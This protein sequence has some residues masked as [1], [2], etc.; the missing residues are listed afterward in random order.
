MRIKSDDI[1]VMLKRQKKRLINYIKYHD[2][3]KIIPDTFGN[4][5]NF[6]AYHKSRVTGPEPCV[7]YAPTRSIYID[8]YGKATPCCFNRIYVYGQYP[9]NSLLE[10]I[11]GDKR[12]FLQHQLC[13]SNFM[14]GCQ[15]C[16][17]LIESGNFEGTEARLYDTLNE[18]KDYPSEIIFEL[19]NI[20]NLECVMCHEGF[21]S[22]IALKKG[23]FFE[24]T[25]YDEQFLKQ[26]SEIIPHV[27]IAKFLGGEP[28]LINVYYKIWDLILTFNPKCKINLQTNG[29]IFNDKIKTYLENGNFFIG[30]SIDSLNKEKF[31]SIR[32]GADFN[33][34]MENFEKFLKISKQ[35]SNYLNVSVCPMQQN[36]F[37]IPDLVK[38]CNRKGVFI[39]FNTVYTSGF[40]LN[41][42]NYSELDNIVK[43]LRKAEIKTKDYI[44]L[45]NKKFYENLLHSI[46]KLCDEKEQIARPFLKRHRFTSL[47]LKEKL[48]EKLN[49]M[50][51]NIYLS[52]DLFKEI[53]NEFYLSD[54][55]LKNLENISAI[56]IYQKL[57][58]ESVDE[59][60]E[61]IINFLVNGNFGRN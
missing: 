59:I 52:D 21:S 48:Q 27:K 61:R 14:Y 32:R 7:C 39:Y 4:K 55:D 53:P 34:V 44:S 15:H 49:M 57:M 29:T 5:E 13:R 12:K 37:E 50:S 25:N 47:M 51:E 18:N 54:E 10:L 56:D 6:I 19:D 24:K 2:I 35:K 23:I 1:I 26:L 22:R 60:K 43:F 42:L 16:H 3:D 45:R 41:E 33:A 9:Q 11:R 40:T 17:K 36:I 38:F 28:F 46:E 30:I 31:E 20:C 58:I 8:M